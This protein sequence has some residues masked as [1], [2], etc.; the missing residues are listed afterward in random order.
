MIMIFIVIIAMTFCQLQLART[1]L[2]M[3]TAYLLYAPLGVFCITHSATAVALLI[4]YFVIF[5]K[6]KKIM[7]ELVGTYIAF[8]MAI[9]PI[10]II[11]DVNIGTQ[12]LD[13]LQCFNFLLFFILKEIDDDG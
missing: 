7:I 13:I 6:R 4:I 8:A 2:S 3:P 10:Y 11:I 12:T 9:L 1:L 5:E